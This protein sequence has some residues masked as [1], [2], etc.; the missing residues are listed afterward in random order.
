LPVTAD[1]AKAKKLLAEAGYPNGKGMPEMKLFITLTKVI[2][3]LLKQFKN[4]WKQLGINVS[5]LIWNGK[6]CLK[7]DRKKTIW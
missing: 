2:K 3:R 6:Y 4:M 5:F 1:L 7:E